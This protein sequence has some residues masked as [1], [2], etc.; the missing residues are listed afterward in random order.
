MSQSQPE[1]DAANEAVTLHWTYRFL[2]AIA[3]WG[4][5]TVFWGWV[6]YLAMAGQY[7]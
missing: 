7:P 5:A 1:T 2:R 4:A 3:Y 6:V